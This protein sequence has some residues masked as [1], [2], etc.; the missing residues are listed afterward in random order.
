MRR[1]CFLNTRAQMTHFS[2]GRTCLYPFNPRT[3]YNGIAAGSAVAYASWLAD[4]GDEFGIVTWS[5]TN[6]CRRQGLV[7]PLNAGV[8]DG[9]AD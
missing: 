2:R 4:A 9:R 8:G 6:I 7:Q 3:V 1:G 5:I